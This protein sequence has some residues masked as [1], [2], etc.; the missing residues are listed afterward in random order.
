MSSVAI[1]A[2]ALL[3]ASHRRALVALA[4]LVV[5]LSFLERQ[6]LAALAPTVSRDLGLS[7]TGYGLA[8][9]AF[10]LAHVLALPLAGVFL[11]RVGVRR[12]L[13]LA[14]ALWSLV[15]AAHGLAAG[16]G[17]LI[18]LR[19]LL[20]ISEA[21]SSP[22]AAQ[23]VRGVLAPA[24]VPRGMG[25]VFTGASVGT[26]AS[27]FVAVALEQRFGWRVAFGAV[28]AI[29]AAWI[30]LWAAL[31]GSGDAPA[32]LDGARAEAAA[33]RRWALSHPAV[34]RTALFIFAIAPILAFGLYWAPKFLVARYGI[35]QAEVARYSFLPPL[36]F[37]LGAIVFGDL[38]SRARRRNASRSE[39]ALVVVAASLGLAIGWMARPQTPWAS[40]SLAAAVCFG[41]GGAFAMTSAAA[42]LAVPRSMVSRAN[43]MTTAAA[44]LGAIV[45]N[46]LIGWSVDRTGS[47][48][49]ALRCLGLLVLPGTAAWLLLARP[50][51]AADPNGSRH[52]PEP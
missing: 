22:G 17:S 38:A 19:I 1:S 35:S 6:T 14:V 43:A 41:I 13:V 52:L 23:I 12:G 3:R 21:P 5:A 34:L 16:L 37:D 44:A 49:L 25:L 30:P 40:V 31:S 46:P 50:E 8:S 7:N 47:Y 33:P 51:S 36:A 4:V 24:D 29:S 10:P 9:S 48:S 39:A 20:G 27:L 18:A 11:D 15:A 2:P 42:L 26:A 32:L 45:S 28:A